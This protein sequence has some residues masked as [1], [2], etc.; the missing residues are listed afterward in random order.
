MNFIAGLLFFAA[1]L[2]YVFA[3]ISGETTPSP[4][5]WFIW[6]A[7]DTLVLVAM[8]REKAR[9]GQLIGA[10]MGAWLIT[11]LAVFYGNPT[12][13]PVEWISIAGAVLGITLWKYT[14]RAL[15]AIICSNV[16][17]FIGSFPTFANAYVDPATEDPV[18]WSIWFVS[19]IFALFAV[20]KWDVANA[21]QPVTFFVIETIMV[22]LVV[23]RPLITS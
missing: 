22:L 4:V 12:M 19:C 20:R 6:A 13:D 21:M 3:I 14:G 8:L 15:L 18:A 23:V 16:V 2:P 9:S 11:I 17:I 5:T 7:V 1:F 10:V